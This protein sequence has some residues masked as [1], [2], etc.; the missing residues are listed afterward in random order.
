MR[1]EHD[2]L[3]A[4]AIR[5]A[6]QAHPISAPLSAIWAFLR[7][8]ETEIV[9]VFVLIAAF[10]AHALNMLHF[11]Y[12]EDDEGTYMS[13]AWAAQTGRGL[14]I[15]TYWYD[16]PPVGWMQIAGWLTA[17]RGL[18]TFGTAIFS[19]RVFMAF[20]HVGSSLLLFKIGRKLSGSAYLSAAAVLLFSLSPLAVYFQRRVLLDNIM[21]FWVLL[22]LYLIVCRYRGNLGAILLSG[23][24]LGIGMLSKEGAFA[25]IPAFLYAIWA[26]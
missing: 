12:M 1:A 7:E 17:T 18:F 15:Y 11:P 14:A 16:H 4:T 5:S 26:V 6:E 3:P 9:L 21:T 8:Y 22:A 10:L 20:L 23:C 19:G 2:I 25:F 13:Q 24:A